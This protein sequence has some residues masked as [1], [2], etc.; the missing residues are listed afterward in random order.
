M[1]SKHQKWLSPFLFLHQG[2]SNFLERAIEEEAIPFPLDL[3]YYDF[4]ATNCHT[5]DEE[6][7]RSKAE[8]IL[9]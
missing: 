7:K 8:W 3:S 1:M 5:A 9:N 2:L 6:V 4:V